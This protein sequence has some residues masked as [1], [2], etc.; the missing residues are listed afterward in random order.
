MNQRRDAIAID[1]T[2]A[3]LAR[4][5]LAFGQPFGLSAA[6]TH[7]LADLWHRNVKDLAVPDVQSAVDEWIRK[8]KKWPTVADIRGDAL[9]LEGVRRVQQRRTESDHGPLPFC[10]GCGTRDLFDAPHGRLKPVH[11]ED[12]HL[13]HPDDLREQ[14]L[15]LSEGAGIW[16]DGHPHEGEQ[17]RQAELRSRHP[18]SESSAENSELVGATS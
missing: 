8:S 1:E 13:V 5:T 11:R 18:R 12:C 3:V 9:K 16:R 15:S 10:L 17:Q 4:L 14:R 7:D 2:R 6:A